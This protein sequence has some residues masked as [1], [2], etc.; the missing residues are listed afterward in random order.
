MV[1][2]DHS[3]GIQAL[4]GALKHLPSHL[5]LP[6]C[7]QLVDFL[8]Q[9]NFLRKAL[10]VQAHLRGGE[11]CLLREAAPEPQD[12]S[13]AHHIAGVSDDAAKQL[14]VVFA[15]A[16]Q[17]NPA[18]LDSVAR[19][20]QCSPQAVSQWFELRNRSIRGVCKR[21]EKKYSSFECDR[22][23]LFQ[24]S[25]LSGTAQPSGTSRLL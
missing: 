11:N 7:D 22:S 6:V 9:A 1:S 8:N 23:S 20:V 5:R 2:D 18:L 4:S 14:E 19:A 15:T 16:S 25:I 10:H 17:L 13:Q 21:L 3:D 12:N 24:R